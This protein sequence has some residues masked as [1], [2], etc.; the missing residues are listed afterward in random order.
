[1]SKWM[2]G[3]SLVLALVGLGFELSPSLPGEFADKSETQRAM[4]AA[5]NLQCF[6][7]SNVNQTVCFGGTCLTG[8]C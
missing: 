2:G 4:G 1:M 7:V 5:T 8:G 6:T 3:L